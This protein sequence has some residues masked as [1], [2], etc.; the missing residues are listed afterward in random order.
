MDL[1]FFGAANM[2]TGSKL[3]ILIN[4]VGILVDCGMF[5]GEGEVENNYNDFD[6]NPKEISYVFLTHSHL[7]HCG[8][9]PKLVRD[10]FN[11]S[12][13][14]TQQT[15]LITEII[16]KDAAKIQ[17]INNRSFKTKIIYNNEDVLKTLSLFKVINP[18][19]DV[20]LD[21]DLKF[22][23]IPAGHILGACSV[24]VQDHDNEYLF[25]GDIGRID[26]SLIHSF[27]DFDFSNISPKTITM[28]ALYGGGEHESRDENI[29][30]I[31]DIINQTIN[32]GGKVLIPIF[33]LQRTQ[34]MLEIFK[35][36]FFKKLIPNDSVVFLDSPMAISITDIYEQSSQEFNNS[37]FFNNEK[38]SFSNEQS[39]E[40]SNL[41]RFKFNQLKELRKSK[42]EGKISNSK[43]SIILAGSGMAD[44]GRI[45][46]HIQNYVG[47]SKNSIIF[48]GFQAN[49]TLGRRLV[50][51]NKF[52]DINGENY[53]VKANISYLRGFSAHGDNNDLITWL[54]KFDRSKLQKVF[55]NHAE[56]EKLQMFANFLR[57]KGYN[58][59]IASLGIAYNID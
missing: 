50:D 52:V 58:V 20:S 33:S 47:D 39:D 19:V 16:L 31:V 42:S 18:F 17:E 55:L 8:M 48:V 13:F 46:K 25:S 11:G 14:L 5:Q 49:G 3:R 22:K 41:N 9:L 6:F 36:L 28:E 1:Q 2:V 15:A 37:L 7:D 45:V 29:F 35:I 40:F 23:F 24:L 32:K 56:P 38:F 21:S 57:N 59:E 34:E 10:G 30:K 51:G 4:G 43:K 53:E 54:E 44:G 26:Q 12:I 27:N